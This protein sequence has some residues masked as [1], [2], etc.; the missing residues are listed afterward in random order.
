MNDLAGIILVSNRQPDE[1]AVA[2]AEEEGITVM[3]SE[4]PAFEVAGRLYGLGVRG[5]GG[6]DPGPT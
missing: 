4:L 1:D 2:K 3:V 5:C 6:Q